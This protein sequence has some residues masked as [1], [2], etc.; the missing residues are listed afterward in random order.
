[1]LQWLSTDFSCI[2][3][4][5]SLQQ[6]QSVFLWMHLIFSNMSTKI[7]SLKYTGENKLD[8]SH[9]MFQY[10]SQYTVVMNRSLLVRASILLVLFVILQLVEFR[11][12]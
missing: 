2:Y 1:M 7:E 11:V 5:S 12:S 9:I 4:S 3:F 8:M 6:E 10:F